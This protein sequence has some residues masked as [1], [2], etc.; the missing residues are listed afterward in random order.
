MPKFEDHWAS[1]SM[2]PN[3][4][5]KVDILPANLRAGNPRRRGMGETPELKPG[6]A[7]DLL[8]PPP[9]CSL[10]PPGEGTV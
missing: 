1:I 5:I 8:M 7:W 6:G 10:S 9:A 3:G 4:G 2:K